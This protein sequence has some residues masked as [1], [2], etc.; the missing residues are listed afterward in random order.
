[1]AI[2]IL[3][4][5]LAV[6]GIFLVAWSITEAFLVCMP[7]TA[8][9]VFYLSGSDAEVEQQI[10]SCLWMKQRHGLPGRMLFVDCGISPQAQI[11]AQLLLK[12]EDTVQLCAPSQVAEYIRWENDTIGSGAD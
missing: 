1:M 6:C 11:T 8:V 12:N 2:T 3:I 7:Q 4:A 10:R 5:A 9:H